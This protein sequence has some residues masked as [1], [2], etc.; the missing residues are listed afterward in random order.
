MCLSWTLS[1][2]GR[3]ARVDFQRNPADICL[4][5]LLFSEYPTWWL[6]ERRTHAAI[7]KRGRPNLPTA[8]PC[9]AMNPGRIVYKTILQI[10]KQYSSNRLPL[11]GIVGFSQ[12]R[13]RYPVIHAVKEAFN[14]HYDNP[15]LDCKFA[16]QPRTHTKPCAIASELS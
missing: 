5:L 3:T 9:T 7:S 11:T 8:S 4:R 10:N 15:D 13:F 12:S 6:R 14:T 2:Q 1:E 16:V